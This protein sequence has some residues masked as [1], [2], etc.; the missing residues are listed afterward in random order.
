[1]KVRYKIGEFT[2][3]VSVCPGDK[4]IVSITEP[5]GSKQEVCE[6]ITISMTT[7]HWVMFYIPGVGFGGI[8][9][10]RNI[11]DKMSEIFV[12]PELVLPDENLMEG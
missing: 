5:D 10:G 11:V 8:F 7:T 12:D 2:R 3:S 9:G 4:L 1:M 6:D